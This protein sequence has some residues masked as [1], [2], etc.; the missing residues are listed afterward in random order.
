MFISLWDTI[1]FDRKVLKPYS[2]LGRCIKMYDKVLIKISN[3]V[4]L[5][6]NTH[7]H[8]VIDELG[9]PEKKGGFLYVGANTEIFHPLQVEKSNK[10]RVFWCGNVLPLQGV[11]IILKAAKL[12]GDNNNIE[13]FL[14]GP[15]RKK[16]CDL[17]KRLSLSNV[18]FKDR[19]SY[20][21]L[22][23]E[24]CKSHL[25]LGG[26]FGIVPKSGRVIAGKT[27]QFLSC[28]IPTVVGDCGANREIFEDEDKLIRFVKMG[29]EYALTDLI[30]K[31]YV[32]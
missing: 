7:L 14:V 29:D 18:I 27:F 30:N 32:K 8:Y 2:L 17:I 6:T 16:Y 13:F 3:F 25:C 19:V 21:D 12:L 24:I 5:D 1:C 26:H 10:F 11:E 20:K 22:S 4:L 28:G 15:V 31:Y 9:L 23:S